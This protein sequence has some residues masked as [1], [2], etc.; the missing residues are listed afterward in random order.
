M[1]V[2]I[3]DK[4]VFKLQHCQIIC[5]FI[6]KMF[7]ATIW[8]VKCSIR[9]AKYEPRVVKSNSG[10][11]QFLKVKFVLVIVTGWLIAIMLHT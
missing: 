3:F 6:R 11:Y 2:E 10:N 4:N 8:F 7:S 9:I 1:M 5:T